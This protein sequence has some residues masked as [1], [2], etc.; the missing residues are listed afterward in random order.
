M[1]K[2]MRTAL[3]GMSDILNNLLEDINK[4]ENALEEG[5]IIKCINSGK[6]LTINKRDPKQDEGDVLAYMTECGTLVHSDDMEVVD[7]WGC[8]Y[9]IKKNTI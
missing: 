1:N 5:T 7:L 3:E 9:F 4:E 2:K 8:K 6:Y